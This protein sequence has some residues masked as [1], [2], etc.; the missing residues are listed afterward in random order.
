MFA[1]DAAMFTILPP[2]M[3]AA[4]R[5]ERPLKACPKNGAALFVMPAKTLLIGFR[6][7]EQKKKKLKEKIKRNTKIAD[8]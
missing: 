7:A 2:E 1:P 5:L 4:F 8:E 3:K 6:T